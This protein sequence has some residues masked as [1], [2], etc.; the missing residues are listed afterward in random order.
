M[1]TLIL[2]G[3]TGSI[4]TQTL[5]VVQRF[6]DQYKIIGLSGGRNIRLLKEQIKTFSPQYVC[7]TDEADAKDIQAEFPNIQCFF[8][9]D[10]L[11]ELG[12]VPADM[13]LVS[14]AGT[15]ALKVTYTLIKNK[16]D[17]ALAS[18]EVLVSA[19]QI[20][21]DLCKT[22]GVDMQ[23]VDSEHAALKQCLAAFSSL[24]DIQNLILTA[25]GGPFWNRSLDT[26]QT[27]KIEDA[28]KH[29][30]WSMGHKITIDSATLMNK[31][32]EL[33]EAHYLFG[34]PYEKL[35]AIIHPSSIIH[36]I[37]QGIDGNTISQ[38]AIANMELPIQYA[39]SYPK[40][41]KATDFQLNLSDQKPMT[42][43]EIDHQKVSLI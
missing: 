32:L 19:G 6:P 27:I 3:S 37:A 42:F 20:I 33:I 25:S 31:A 36:A 43:H 5:S 40:R 35:S 10:G 12:N 21:M 28:L 9:E 24:D 23:P 39:L 18:K 34:I 1:K 15:A 4:G 8:G 11:V 29:P 7:V 38:M 17:I 16:V 41:L 2:L 30:N 13:A 26:F 14:I 22:Q